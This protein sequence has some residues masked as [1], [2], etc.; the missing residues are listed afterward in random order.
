MIDKTKLRNN[1]FIYHSHSII[2]HLCNVNWA[3]ETN[4]T[5]LTFTLGFKVWAQCNAA[6]FLLLLI[7]GIC[8]CL[9][10]YIHQYANN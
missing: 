1:H 8:I 7:A 3:E 4:L 9:R 10:L 5:W 6:S 2:L